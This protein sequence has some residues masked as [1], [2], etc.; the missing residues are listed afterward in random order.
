MATVIAFHAHPDDEALW[1]GGTLAL[2]AAAG[3]RVVIVVAT[4]GDLGDGT[5]PGAGVRLG[6][7]AASAAALGAAAV[8]YLGYADS[9]H[10]PLLYADPDG[11]RRFVR[12]PVDEAAERLAALLRS[13]AAD[14]LI[15][16]DARGG[17]GHRDHVQVHRV[18]AR[19]AALAGGVRVLEAT[20]PRERVER[21]VRLARL[22]V[23]FRP[24]PRGPGARPEP[25][26]AEP[27]PAYTPD[28]PMFTPRRE[29]AYR[30]DVRRH[31]RPKRAALAAHV[32]QLTGHAAPARLRRLAVRLPVALFAVL[33]GREFFNDS[34]PSTTF[35]DVFTPRP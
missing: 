31:A 10:G 7:L 25:P 19:A 15:S 9:G 22:G 1:T 2:L 17:Y 3:H 6:E 28:P 24:A 11:R 23:V 21:L 5:G 16:Y 8:E 12:V 13:E 18:G 20:L 32:S 14:V 34:T 35:L 4:D 27:D 26:G 30:V 33:G 29:I